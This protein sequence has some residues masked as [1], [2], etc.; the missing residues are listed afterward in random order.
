VRAGGPATVQHRLHILARKLTCRF[1]IEHKAPLVFF[2]T[3]RAL[4]PVPV[5]GVPGMHAYQK[6]ARRMCSR[7]WHVSSSSSSSSGQPQRT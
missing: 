2:C 7:R 3:R 4:L 6:G 5:P 1:V